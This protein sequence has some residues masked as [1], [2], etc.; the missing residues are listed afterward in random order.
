MTAP[1]VECHSPLHDISTLP[2]STLTTEELNATSGGSLSM[3][4]HSRYIRLH[5]RLAQTIFCECSWKLSTKAQWRWRRCFDVVFERIGLYMLTFC[6]RA[7]VTKKRETQG[8]S[9]RCRASSHYVNAP[10]FEFFMLFSALASRRSIIRLAHLPGL[11]Q[12]LAP[13]LFRYLQDIC[14][15][16]VNHGAELAGTAGT[17]FLHHCLPSVESGAKRR[18]SQAGT[19]C[20]P[21][22][23]GRQ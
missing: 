12:T 14:I 5:S 16:L 4:R 18:F 10:G 13:R 11:R 17:A 15:L 1:V 9:W 22:W 2:E 3:K 23:G 19:S 20:N 7:V 6:W 21:A 8:Y